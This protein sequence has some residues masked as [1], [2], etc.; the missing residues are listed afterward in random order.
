MTSSHWTTPSK[1][2]YRI[3]TRFLGFLFA[4]IITSLTTV[5]LFLLRDKLNTSTVALLYF[6]PILVSTTLWGLWPGVL[7]A[8][9]AFFAYNFFFLKPYYTLQVHNTQD[10]LALVIFLIVAVL[11]SQL[12][13]QARSSLSAAVA[14]ESE[15][16]RLYELS[17]DLAGVN[18][19]DEI[20][21]AIARKTTE[22]VRTNK[23]EISIQSLDSETEAPFELVIPFDTNELQ[24]PNVIIPLET[25][26]AYFGEIRLWLNEIALAAG[27]ERLLHA[28]AA[29]AAL[30][31]ERT[32]LAHVETQAKVLE[33][34]DRLKSAL[35]SSV[36]HEFRTP[37]ATIKASTTSLLGDEIR[38][39]AQE[40]KELLSVI[41]EEAD[42]LNYLVGNLLDM[43]RIEAGALRP[44]RQWN[45]L[46]EILDSVLY[47]MRRTLSNF[48]V[49]I[50]FPDDLPF[51]P[52]D[53]SQ[54]EQ[55]FINLLHNSVKY[56]PEN[57]TI[58]IK[59][60]I[61]KEDTIMLVLSNEGPHVAPEHLSRIFDKFYRITEPEKVSGTGLGLSICKGIIEAHGGRIWAEN[62]SNGLAFI[63][64]LPLVLDGNPP[65][66]IEAENL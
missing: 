24:E 33:E 49:D 10:I 59:A 14:R 62:I 28:F 19:F 1:Q 60:L 55:V 6:L 13:G 58:Q 31:I 51:V 38:W 40:R 3:A 8:F 22:T 53:Y 20:A 26:R 43:S 57:S 17:L 44:N 64:T 16:T 52:V 12:V 9:A 39:E 30:A 56:A 7:S 23:L 29:Q 21:S 65:P 63:F 47:R 54:M 5:L 18:S 45:V 34:S 2:S 37:L 46:S 42:Y 32:A 11:I 61:L 36:S 50:Q 66:V 15:T 25:V 48:Q 35:L 41:D 4:I 27:D